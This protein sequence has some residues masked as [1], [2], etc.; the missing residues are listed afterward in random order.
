M[1]M[2][3]NILLVLIGP[4]GIGKTGTSIELAKKWN[5]E[6]ISCDS[7]Q[8]YREMEIGTA[9]PSPD[10]LKAVK[11]HFIGNL[12]IHDYY[13]VYRYEVEVL[14]LLK[15]IFS[16]QNIAIITG[17][18]GLYL[19]AVLFGMDDIPD[20][21]PI[22]RNELTRRIEAEGVE[23]LAAELKKI[24]PDYYDQTDIKNPKRILRG[25]ETWYSTGTRFSSYRQKNTAAREF[26]P[27]IINLDIDRAELYSRINTRVNKMVKS[28]LREEARSL[29]PHRGLN[30]LNTVGYKEWFAHFDGDY[31]EEEAVRLI[32]R[33]TR[34]YAK[35]QITWNKKYDIALNSD[36]AD[37]ETITEFVEKLI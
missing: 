22:V 8:M 27:L 30:A 35:R 3:D 11:H 6:I 34:H 31:G 25:L 24:D 32:K 16:K 18:S 5:A 19:D 12:S 7:R 2:P 14:Q 33:N 20:I 26:K 1:N 10:Q 37:I 29:Y 36:P 28:G 15:S 4:T 21:D 13:N 9:V 23:K 17:G